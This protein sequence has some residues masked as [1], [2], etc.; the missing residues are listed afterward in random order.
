MESS[1]D[2]SKF[3]IGLR[4][5]NRR[6][7]ILASAL[8]L[9]IL[10]YGLFSAKAA[11][12]ED[13]R[14]GSMHNLTAETTQ[15]GEFLYQ[16]TASDGNPTTSTDRI[17]HWTAPIVESPREVLIT[18]MVS[19]PIEG[20]KEIKELNLLVLPYVAALTITETSSA[21]TASVGNTIIYS[22]NVLN[23]GNVTL[24]SLTLD[25][26][27]IGKIIPAKTTLVPEESTTATASY[28]VNSSDLPGPLSNTFAAQATDIQGKAVSA[29]AKTTV[30]LTQAAPK[31]NIEKNCIFTSPVRVSDNVVYTYNVTN[32][33][34]QP[35]REVSLNDAY[36]W[37]PNCQPAYVKGDD[38]NRVLDPGESW[39]YECRYVVADPNDYPTLRIMS[40]GSSSAR[41]AD[42]IQKLM[43]M[44]TRLEI[45]MSNLRLM[46]KRF[47]PQAS[48]LVVNHR[49]VSGV[50][51]TF[52]NYTN[53]VLA[54]SFSKMIDPQGRLNKTTYID[55]L[56]EAIFTSGYDPSGSISSE[57]VYYPGTKEYLRIQYDIPFLGYKTYTA[58]DYRKGDTLLLVVD[59]EGHILSKEYKKT[60]GYRLF[61]EKFF[62]KNTVTVTARAADG[63]TV[64]DSDSFTLEIFRQLPI[65]KIT[66]TADRNTVPRGAFL[67]YTVAYENQGGED[68][69]GVVIR[70]T[71]DRNL[72]FMLSDRAPDF[73]TSDRWTIGD[74]KK[75]ESGNIRIMTKVSSS[76]ASGL[77]I[78]NKVDM[79][80]E[81]N[82]T[83]RDII[84]TIVASI[85]LNLTKTASAKQVNPGDFLDYTIVYQNSGGTDVHEAVVKE[86]YDRNFL[87]LSASPAPEAGT[88][89][90]WKI[91]DFPQRGSGTITIKGSVSSSAI[92]GTNIT[93]R[94]CMTSRENVS[95]CAV[96]NTTVA[97]LT[98]TKSAS[99]DIVGK[100]GA[101]T[102]TIVYKNDAPFK[103]T[104][105][106]IDDY[107]DKNVIPGIPS[108]DADIK[109]PNHYTWKVPDLNPGEERHILL[110][111]T[112]TADPNVNSIMNI[113][114]IHS[115]NQIITSNAT[116]LT[117]V[118]HSLWINKTADKKMYNRDENITY[119]I[120]YGNANSSNL[121]ATNITIEDILPD[122]DLLGVSPVPSSVNGNILKWSIKKLAANENG[123]IMLYMH[124]PK[125]L[126]IS[127]DET[128][129]VRGEGYVHVSRLLSTTVEKSA[130]I[131]RAN[132]SGE[133]RM[134]TD[135][136][137]FISKDSS[138]SAVTI[139]GSPGTELR[140][141]EH[142][143]GHYEE[144]EKSS[145]RL[146]NK[147]ITMQ[148][149]LFAKHGKTTFSLPCKRSIEYD[150]LWSDLS[151]GKNRVLNDVVSENY[152]YTDML[153]KNSSYILD[154]NQTVYRS[155][156]EFSD[157]LAHIAYRKQLPDSTKSIVELSED[158]HG[159]F[160][161]KE[162]ID[163]YG[164]NVKYAKSSKGKGFIA[165]DKRP[166]RNQRSFEHG[167][168]YYNSEETMQLDGIVKDL[169]MLYAP[170]NQ[171][172]GSQNINYSNLWE[173]GMRTKDPGKGLVI[174]EAIR[175]ASYIDKE[176]EMG[177][178]SLSILGEFNGSM[179]LQLAKGL[180]SKIEEIRLDQTLVGS[181]RMDTSL[182]VFTAPKHL[183]P[184][185]NI[186][187]KA[188]MQDGETVLFLIDVT[189]DGNK[190]LK[191]VEV[192][193][194]LP[195]GLTFINS[196]IR[197]EVNGQ[198]INW[199]I[200]SLD[201]S[202]SLTIK[203]R[204][205]VVDGRQWYVNLVSAR[206]NY[207]DTV[208][209]AKNY[210]RFEAYYQ[211]LPCCPKLPL[212]WINS[213]GRFNVTPI[214]AEW[215][216]WKP[217]PCFNVSTEDKDCFAEIEE[218]YNE[219]DQGLSSCCASNYEVP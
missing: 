206:A 118:V 85:G 84:N 55:P 3:L 40:D 150:S 95:L 146:E 112:I 123:V 175:S 48:I 75:G 60:P 209:E 199:T 166:T 41:M 30:D 128:S 51:Y 191:P 201:T 194:R 61:T 1:T 101:L 10:S 68:A 159:S 93:N 27:K 148:R 176:A 202:R 28:K 13:I 106:T 164:D 169:K 22:F 172:A 47:N 42:I 162:F 182:S 212:D 200:P 96:I 117:T 105:V 37:G 34:G 35:L 11:S 52:Y 157:G 145:L 9:I 142:G 213:T 215:G 20:C 72:Q 214:K 83:A 8:A 76:V 124:I 155:D 178:S 152:H 26:P 63:S 189:N 143:S 208:L 97:G 125:Q 153:S 110:P 115:D 65:L 207:K 92:R 82:V 144:D 5:L 57:E 210:T 17:F 188:I 135:T 79:T 88:N 137:P 180:G 120:R 190:L 15:G 161:V 218:Y 187:K 163:S 114:N 141:S 134:G 133:Y 80:C 46:A 18:L 77:I 81:E 192:S 102:Y 25:N 64:S 4:K 90:T 62:L 217:A 196:S 167:S 94:A 130:L 103:Q 158:Y 205:K 127:F 211:P 44:K 219:L 126:N 109:L 132:I 138:T 136:L 49:N 16:W 119:T 195:D 129:S 113:Y 71:Y 173:E 171:T 31:I 204:A 66:K 170:A 100:G 91:G 193:D 174:G 87:F 38:G 122:I 203:L 29:I 50:N 69:H 154:M 185:L 184:H 24:S 107:L 2:K 181:F 67:N 45:K 140:T 98:I 59:A 99:P 7:I 186:S 58:T 198:I 23:T 116:L 54:E 121:D 70:E 56:S 36:N 32:S 6:S 139:L 165:S 197:P 104:N 149:D 33:G 147:S 216:A 43:E 73:G 111:V 131:N 21:S 19:P 151:R 160:K 108:P 86:T 74:L 39:W 156:A 168:G 53:E 14:S 89:D 177:K 12:D 183:Y 179:N 78:K